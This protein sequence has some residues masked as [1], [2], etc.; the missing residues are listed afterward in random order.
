M[1]TAL[2]CNIPTA[3]PSQSQ[4]NGPP[5][6]GDKFVEFRYAARRK[7]RLKARQT[8][9]RRQTESEPSRQTGL[10]TKDGHFTRP[11]PPPFTGARGAFTKRSPTTG[12][13]NKPVRAKI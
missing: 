3:I 4:Q 10:G 2:S 1:G 6:E 11:A 7:V 8:E 13:G 5:G 9:K 12:G